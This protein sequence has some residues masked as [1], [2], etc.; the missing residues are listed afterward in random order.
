VPV[1]QRYELGNQ[2]R[3]LDDI[4]RKL[5]IQTWEDWYKIKVDDFEKIGG[6]RLLHKYKGSLVRGNDTVMKL[7]WRSCR[8]CIGDS[9]AK[10]SRRL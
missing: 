4:G 1:K 8:D 3:F 5:N 7:Y 10:G 9:I 2:R 6:R